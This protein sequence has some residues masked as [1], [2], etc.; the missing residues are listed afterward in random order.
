MKSFCSSVMNVMSVYVFGLACVGLMTILT[1]LLL[2][3]PRPHF[4]QVKC[5]LLTYPRGFYL[6][7]GRYIFDPHNLTAFLDC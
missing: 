6:L 7:W 3:R 5:S 2:G 4:F 1:K